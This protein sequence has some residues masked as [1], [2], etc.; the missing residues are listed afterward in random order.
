MAADATGVWFPTDGY[1]RLGHL[2]RDGTVRMVAARLPG[3]VDALA[4]PGDGS[5][6]F[7]ARDAGRGEDGDSLWRLPDAAA[8]LTDPLPGC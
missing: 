1:S 5:V 7:I 3:Q 4:A 2:A 6:L 8:A